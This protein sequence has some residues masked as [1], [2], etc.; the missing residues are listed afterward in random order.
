VKTWGIKQHT[1]DSS[2]RILISHTGKPTKFLPTAQQCGHERSTAPTR[3]R[4]GTSSATSV[5][6]DTHVRTTVL[7][8]NE[9]DLRFCR[10]AV[11]CA[12]SDWDP[13]GTGAFSSDT[14]W[15][16]PAVRISKRAMGRIETRRACGRR[17]EYAAHGRAGDCWQSWWQGLWSETICA[18]RAQLNETADGNSGGLTIPRDDGWRGRGRQV[19]DVYTELTAICARGAG[20][21]EKQR[22]CVEGVLVVIF[23]SEAVGETRTHAQSAGTGGCL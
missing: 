23:S 20:H 13:A 18:H 15:T 11:A 10:T 22:A 3:R 19:R 16:L 21:V 12:L 7:E 2:E 9:F 8:L 5:Y 17:S 6:L 1:G 4:S 14:A